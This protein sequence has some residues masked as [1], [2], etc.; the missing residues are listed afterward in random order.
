MKEYKLGDLVLDFSI[1]PR[2]EV[3]SQHAS[4][5]QEA[6]EGGAVLPPMVIEKKTKRVVDGFHRHR[7]YKRISGNDPEFVV[8]CIEKTYTSE[9]ALFL[10]AMRFNAEHGRALTKFDRT[11]CVLLAMQLHVPDKDIAK[12]LHINVDAV[13]KLTVDRTAYGTNG[14][15]KLTPIKRTI[16]HKAGQKLT[17]EQVKCNGKL[18]GQEQGFYVHQLV[19]LIENELL[20]TE[21]ER[22][23]E[24]IRHLYELLEG[25]LVAK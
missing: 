21:N 6:I 25:V 8:T 5:I 2:K 18:G 16:L 14:K 24:Q 19:M 11:H 1:Y 9:A 13:Q 12:V 15:Q 10:D 3:D 23:M 7:A 17:K 20:D 4:I 22:L